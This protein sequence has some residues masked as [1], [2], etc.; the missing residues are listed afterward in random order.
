MDLQFKTQNGNGIPNIAVLVNSLVGGGA[1][2]IALVS[3]KE[4]KSKGYKVSLIC[5]ENEDGYEVPSDVPV[6]FLTD[7]NKLKNP[8]IKVYWIIRSAITLSKL[9]KKNH[10]GFVQSHLVRS[11]F[12]NVAAKIFGAK[13][14]TQLV[15]HLPINF[16]NS[17]FP[18]RLF[19]SFFYA[20]F[21]R[22][23]D[24][25]VSISNLMKAE[26]ENT[27]SLEKHGVN[28]RVV[29]NPHNL[30]KVRNG[31]LKET[32]IFN[33]SPDKRYLIVAGRLQPHKKVDVTIKALHTIRKEFPTTELVILGEGN[34]RSRLEQLVAEKELT[35]Y[36]HI[37]GRA[38]N[39]HAYIA[40]SE[41]LILSSE[42]EG[43]PN[44][45]IESMACGTPV[46]SSD[47]VSGPREILAPDTDCF[48]RLT[49]DSDME[50]AHYGILYPVDSVELLAKAV[51]KLFESPELAKT[52]SERGKEYV[53]KFDK[54]NITAEYIRHLVP[55]INIP[56]NL[57]PK[58][59]ITA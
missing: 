46:I 5:L 40:R 47:C 14:K 56:Y 39:P 45:L 58:K 30:E 44:I 36:V 53:D 17:I 28:H 59:T 6:Y 19:K 54:K 34:D 16:S 21:Y 15:S 57:K 26:I 33:F 48:N 50:V 20:W 51:K 10:I 55:L 12:I 31:A 18:V 23:A 38:A 25:V 29:Y 52:F 13:H 11:N 2:R 1:E 27:L 7:N 9:I 22:K 8:I 3:L 43:L 41:A 24:E 32:E 35:P 49:L 4:L 42:L 37:L